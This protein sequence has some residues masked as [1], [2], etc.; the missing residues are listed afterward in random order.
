MPNKPNQEATKVLLQALACGA[1]VENAARKAGITER[2]AYRRL[3]DPEFAKQVQQQ[4]ADMVQRTL[5][6]LT[7]AAISSVKTLLDLQQDAAVPAAVKRR[8]AHDVLELARKYRESETWEGRI[9]N[10]ERALVSIPE[11]LP[12][13]A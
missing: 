6:M 4:R 12:R 2:T 8:A 11:G 5:G 9:L 7:G 13:A 10:L 1:T 3:A